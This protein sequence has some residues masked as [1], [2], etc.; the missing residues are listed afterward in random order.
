MHHLIQLVANRPWAVQASYAAHVQG[1]VKREGLA[2]LRHLAELKRA[3]HAQDAH[4][5]DVFAYEDEDYGE[6]P[7]RSGP[8]VRDGVGLVTCIGLMTQRGDYINSAWT[9]STQEMAAEITSL[10]LNARVDAILLEID[11]PGGE[12]YGVPEAWEAIRAAAARKPVIGVANSL[13]ASA[14]LYVGSACT[15]LWCSPS[16]E[17]GSLGVYQMWV[18]EGRALEAEG[19]DIEFITATDSPFKVE[20]NSTQPLSQDARDEMQRGVDR[21][22]RMF[23]EHVFKG[24]KASPAG[25]R[26]PSQ[27]HVLKTF[28][29][30]RMLAPED[31]VAVGMIDRIGTRDEAFARAAALGRK[32]RSEKRG[33]FGAGTVDILQDPVL[34]EDPAPEPVVAAAPL[35][36]P[37]PPPGPT[38]EQLAAQAKLDARARRRSIE[39]GS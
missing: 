29:K 3:A 6:R 7:R 11:S 17:A 5:A 37:A 13:M 24:R 28:G 30:G 21:Y 14:A 2:G 19:I 25:G 16:G 22:M 1:L 39:P 23:V 33:A 8:P 4:R 10:S 9:R 35:A 36:V 18:G 12:V 15:E 34:T 26:V 20:G 38:E 32:W 27:V 31:A